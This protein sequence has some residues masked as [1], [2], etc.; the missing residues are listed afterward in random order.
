MSAFDREQESASGVVNAVKHT[1]NEFQELYLET[2][3]SFYVTVHY[4][5]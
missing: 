5:S 3:I 1:A 2:L 4:M